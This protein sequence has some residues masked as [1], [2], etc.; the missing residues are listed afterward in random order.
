MTFTEEQQK[1]YDELMI[2]GKKDHPDTPN[3]I[4]DSVVR[5]YV[6]NDCKD[7]EQT[8]DDDCIIK[9]YENQKREYNY[10]E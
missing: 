9:I 2:L 5:A 1:Q 10:L 7:I 8:V 6:L 3:M 4:L